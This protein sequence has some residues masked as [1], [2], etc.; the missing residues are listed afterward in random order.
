MRGS[1]D[2]NEQLDIGAMRK[3]LDQFRC[4]VN[5]QVPCLV[6]VVIAVVATEHWLAMH[7]LLKT[8]SGL[9]STSVLILR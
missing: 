8:S 2:F 3:L 6:P 9:L 1:Q 4:L 5:F 7:N